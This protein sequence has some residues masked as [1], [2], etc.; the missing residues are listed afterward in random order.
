MPLFLKSMSGSH[1]DVAV[2][3]PHSWWRLGM[4]WTDAPPSGTVQ[5]VAPPEHTKEY[6]QIEVCLLR[7]LSRSLRCWVWTGAISSIHQSSQGERRPTE[8]LADLDGSTGATRSAPNEESGNDPCDG[9]VT[10]THAPPLRFG[11]DDLPN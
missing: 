3:A 1:H 2:T 8:R 4:S 9:R 6:Y 11:G 7:V 5:T 10:I